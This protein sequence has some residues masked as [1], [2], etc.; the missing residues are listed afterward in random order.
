M[1]KSEHV[2]S[3]ASSRTA[4]GRIVSRW[5]TRSPSPKSARTASFHFDSFVSCTESHVMKSMTSAGSR[6]GS[7]FRRVASRLILLRLQS[8]DTATKQ[9]RLSGSRATPSLAKSCRTTL[10]RT[11]LY[12]M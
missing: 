1:P 7:S 2:S 12:P 10:M 3:Q 9:A 11:S 6:L 8:K 5:I 4:V